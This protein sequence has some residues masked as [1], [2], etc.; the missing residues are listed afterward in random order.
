METKWKQI[1]IT[2]NLST[3]IN[4][5]SLRTIIDN[6]NDWISE[7]AEIAIRDNLREIMPSL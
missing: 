2:T 3:A 7:A 1:P 6:P 4:I 5:S